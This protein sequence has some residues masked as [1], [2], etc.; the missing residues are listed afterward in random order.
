[1]TTFCK[2][3]NKSGSELLTE[4]RTM[5]KAILLVSLIGLTVTITST[6]RPRFDRSW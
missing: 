6:S 5:K 3:A 1:M 4:E 2:L